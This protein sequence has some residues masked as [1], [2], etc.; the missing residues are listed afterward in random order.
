MKRKTTPENIKDQKSTLK[1]QT[2]VGADSFHCLSHSVSL[3]AE[4]VFLHNMTSIFSNELSQKTN[5]ITYMNTAH[6][7]AFPI[8]CIEKIGSVTEMPLFGL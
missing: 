1:E 5:N 4:D 6:W 7:L 8:D 3:N 2:M